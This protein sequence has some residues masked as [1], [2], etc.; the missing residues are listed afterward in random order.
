LQGRLDGMARF[1]R[2]HNQQADS[3]RKLAEEEILWILPGHGR[4]FAFDSAQ[5]RKDQLM[6]AAD[7]YQRDPK[8]ESAPGPL[9]FYP[10]SER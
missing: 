4:R 7:D 6:R 5:E 1:S 10:E 3:I 8:G 2:Y 9:F